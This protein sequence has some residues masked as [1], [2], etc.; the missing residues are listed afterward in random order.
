[1]PGIME[2]TAESSLYTTLAVYVPG[3]VDW[4]ATATPP[5]GSAKWCGPLAMRYCDQRSA[6]EYRACSAVDC[7][8]LCR[9][10]ATAR[11]CAGCLDQRARC[12]RD[13]LQR[14]A[15]CGT[16][17]D[18]SSCMD[19]IG[20]NV[21]LA[22]YSRCCAPGSAPC[23]GNCVSTACGFR[24]QFSNASCSC[25]CAVPYVRSAGGACVCPPTQCPQS[26]PLLGADCQCRPCPPPSTG[27]PDGCRILDSDRNNCGACGVVCAADEACCSGVCTPIY[28]NG[29]CG[30]CTRTCVG[31]DRACCPDST[32]IGSGRHCV[33]LSRDPA[34]CG[35]CGNVCSSY[36]G[37]ICVGGTCVCKPGY[38]A[39]G[40][41]CCA[42]GWA[43]SSNQRNGSECTCPSTRVC[44]DP[45]LGDDRCCAAGEVCC[46][47][48]CTSL[49]TLSDCS[50]CGDRCVYFDDAGNG[51]PGS[52]DPTHHC[53][54]PTG[55]VAVE[56]DANG[57]DRSCCPT[58]TPFLCADGNCGANPGC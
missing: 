31:P 43:C 14:Y 53:R 49:G 1:M 9:E 30:S 3:V 58:A 24:E 20:Q 21:A 6:A 33:D 46:N 37:M 52:C 13:V 32:K 28:S 45:I 10:P 44:H 5:P 57:G 48:T 19:D 11:F 2:L 26:A 7:E 40:D 54:C 36:Y 8:S 29:R 4:F 41:G 15:D 56:R 35:T 12:Q 39:C 18:G 27:C 50:R 23:D 22:P 25:E 47:G 55:T 38:R 17:S 42:P 16:C 51:T 34:N